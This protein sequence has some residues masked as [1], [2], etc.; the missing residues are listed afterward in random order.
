MADIFDERDD[1]IDATVDAVRSFMGDEFQTTVLDRLPTNPQAYE[2][3]NTLYVLLL[4]SGLQS[5]I[6][7]LPYE[8]GVEFM[9]RAAG[10]PVPDRRQLQ[11]IRDYNKRYLSSAVMEIAQEIQKKAR[12]GVLLGNGADAVKGIRGVLA[13]SVTKFANAVDTALNAFDRA[14]LEA[15]SEDGDRWIYVGPKDSKNRPFCAAIL[16]EGRAYTRSQVTALNRHPLLHSYVPPNVKT[17]CGGINCRHVFLPIT[18]EEAQD[19]G[20]AT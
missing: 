2:N 5:A 6:D 12:E 16:S 4:A 15:I 11:T 10:R 17:L 13:K 3:I 1:S 9:T 8:E 18:K 14:I 7:A 19:G 20:Y